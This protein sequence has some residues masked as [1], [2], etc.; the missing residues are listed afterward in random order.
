M[1]QNIFGGSLISILQTPFYAAIE[2]QRVHSALQENHNKSQL[3]FVGM[4]T[5][6]TDHDNSRNSASYLAEENIR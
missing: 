4:L 3:R 5:T 2:L 1:M 6:A